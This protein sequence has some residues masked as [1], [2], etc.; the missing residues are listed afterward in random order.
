MRKISFVIVTFLLLSVAGFGQA[1]F[2]KN[3]VQYKNF[4]WQYIQTKHF[5]IYF[6]TGGEKIADF[7]AEIAEDA[8]R[9]LS[10]DFNYNLQERLSIITYP[11]HNDFGQTNV[12]LGPPEES[13]GGFTEFYKNRMVVPYEGS[14]EKFRHVIHHE[15]THGVMLQMIYGAG[16]GSIISGF[17]RLPLPLWFV[18]GLAEFES[19]GWD[20]ESDMF[21]RDATINGYLPEIERLGGFMA[22]KGG[23]SL[24]AYIAHR[25]GREKIGE[26]LGKIR[27]NRGVERGFK[28]SIGLDLEELSKR[29]HQS[30]KREYWPEVADRQEP[31]EF[32]L[33][34]SDHKHEKNFVNNSPALSPDGDQLAFLS[35]RS[36]YFDIYL[37]S[38]LDKKITAKL[39]SGEKSGHFEE[40]HWL[41]PGISWS[42]DGE[43]ITFAAKRGGKDALY[44][45]EI[46][47]KIKASKRALFDL[48]TGTQHYTFDL[49]GIFSPAWSPGGDQICF[50][51]TKNGASD[52]Y[53]FNLKTGKLDQ[54]T[55]DPFS[56]LDP[57]WSPDGGQIC[58]ASDR[59]TYLRRENIPPGFKIQHF[60]YRQLDLYLVEVETGDLQRLTDTHYLEQNPAWSPNP[61]ILTYVSDKNGINNIYFLNLS[62]GEDYPVTN[63]LTGCFQPTWS[64]KSEKLAF[65]CFFDGGYDIFMITNPFGEDLKKGDLEQTTF[66]KRGPP[67][68]KEVQRVGTDTRGQEWSKG[69]IDYRHYIFFDRYDEEVE[70][71]NKKVSLDSTEYILP[72]GEYKKNEYKPKFSP[73]IVNAVV[74]YSTY[75]GLQGRSQIA[76]SDVLGNHRIYLDTDLYIDFENSNFQVFYFYLPRRVDVGLGLFHY[77]YY[78]DYGWVRDRNYGLISYLSFPFNKYQRIDNLIYFITIERQLY[79]YITNGGEPFFVG[80]MEYHPNV[81]RR[82]LLPGLSW[83]KDTVIWGATGPVNGARRSFSILLSPNL[84]SLYGKK[85]TSEWGLE[86]QTYSADSRWYLKVRK[87]YSFALRLTGGLSQGKNPQRFYLGGVENW[88]NRKFKGGVLRIDKIEDVYFSE[89][90][91][92]FRGGDYYEQVGTRYF[93]FNAEFRYPFIKYLLLGWPLPIGLQNV[94]GALF[95]DLGSA[96]YQGEFKGMSRDPKTGNIYLDDL[97]FSLGTGIRMNLG[98]FLIQIDVAWKKEKIGYAKPRYYFSLGAEF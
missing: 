32:S 74:G 42:P 82:L 69:A 64:Q 60:N 6:T 24:L 68:E 31:Q 63:V 62:T 11:S 39:V 4:Q 92:P 85:S 23:Q 35:D 30:L 22:Y 29:W 84:S 2:G 1:Y 93:L 12:S 54:L 26:I 3:K 44:V 55:Y 89:F 16:F 75:F 66:I 51:G 5:D 61:E 27:V 80:D 47:A 28:K 20:V 78:F 25:Y 79:N 21:M 36:D 98:F 81:K 52:I 77:Y 38:T 50:V 14:Y 8:Y 33:R 53:I 67:P 43:K 87:D 46:Q 41:R 48:G 7:A 49:D 18:E 94:R 97:L 76:V 57:C 72:S 71:A 15:L 90:I 86:F 34:L 96:W 9:Q 70:D 40:L 45:I 56:D 10:S 13:V 83:I 65:T 17:T 58:F 37:M 73:D 95:T 91:T 88:L 59:G 19:R